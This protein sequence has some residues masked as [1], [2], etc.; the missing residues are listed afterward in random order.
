MVNQITSSSLVELSLHLANTSCYRNHNID[1]RSTA[2]FGFLGIFM[3]WNSNRL[4]LV[5][6]SPWPSAA[7]SASCVSS[8]STMIQSS[9]SKEVSF[10]DC[11]RSSRGATSSTMSCKL[12]SPILLDVCASLLLVL[13]LI[14]VLL[15]VAEEPRLATLPV[16]APFAI[17]PTATSPK[18]CLFMLRSVKG[19]Q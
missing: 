4:S 15:A 5:G 12:V 11:S 18:S 13:V 1:I 19:S 16:A 10:I 7:A 9:V 2:N 3:R 6:A 8:W 17:D 14:L